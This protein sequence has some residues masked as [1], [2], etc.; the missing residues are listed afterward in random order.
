VDTLLM[1]LAG[2]I[3]LVFLAM[4]AFGTVLVVGSVVVGL[5]GATGSVA[6]QLGYPMPWSAGSRL[7]TAMWNDVA[8]I[9]EKRW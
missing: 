3:D 8:E 2:G 9:L 5:A 6:Q 7:R 4:T 1:I